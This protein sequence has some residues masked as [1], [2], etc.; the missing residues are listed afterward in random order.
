[1]T[2]S[3]GL[4]STGVPVPGSPGLPSRRLR[5]DRGVPAGGPPPRRRRRVVLFGVV[6]VVLTAGALATGP[7][8]LLDDF[9]AARVSQRIAARMTCPGGTGSS[10]QVTLGGGRLLPQLVH[11][12]LT[13]INL[14]QPDATI[15]D[16]RHAEFSATIRDVDGITTDA[17]RARS[18]DASIIVPFA[19]LPVPAG[20]PPLTFARAQDGS[21]MMTTTASPGQA[22]NV[23]A[24]LFLQLQLHGENLD[25]VPQRL[26]V[27]GHSLPAAKV[28][29]L[30]GGVRRQKLPHLPKGL[31]YTFALPQADGVHVGLNGVVTTPLSALP[32]TVSGR[33]V[34]YSAADGLLGIS[35]SFTVPPIINVPLTIFTAPRLTGETLTLV[36]QSVQILGANRQPDDPIARLVLRQINQSDLT[37]KLP[38][39]PTGVRYKS[40]GVDGSGVKVT[41]GGVTVTPLSE[42]PQPAIG[43]PT[44][45]GAQDGLLTASTRGVSANG[46]RMPIVL[47]ANPRI[48]GNKLDTT[49]QRIA[50]FG[51]QFPAALVLSQIKTPDT[52]RTLQQLPAGLAYAGVDVLPTGLRI[53]VSGKNVSLSK[54][55]M[56]GLTCPH[57]Q[58]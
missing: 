6:L 50:F 42:L 57:G 19:H 5:P 18:V 10:P 26:Q 13:Q 51:A 33:T 37:R 8:P 15:G 11:R 12:R 7:V 48:T 47:Y 43:I 36:P 16:A 14:L 29:S 44:V 3:T 54:T 17:P 34:S 38:A 35:T 25:A 30:T 27:F 53:R 22:K 32:A 2:S 31:A 1:M 58:Q 24:K 52:A 28:G 41:V 45:F 21:L 46:P 56:T 20:Q 9:L 4:T 39:L 49:P 55:A 40:A 23:T